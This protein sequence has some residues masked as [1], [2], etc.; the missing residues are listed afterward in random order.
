MIGT[1]L[2]LFLVCT[3]LGWGISGSLLLSAFLS[4]IAIIVTAITV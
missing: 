3:M 4:L 2:T 1:Y